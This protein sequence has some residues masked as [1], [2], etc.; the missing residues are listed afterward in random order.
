[1]TNPHLVTKVS[2]TTLMSLMSKKM[3]GPA[4]QTAKMKIIGQ[5][6]CFCEKKWLEI[7]QNI[8]NMEKYGK[9]R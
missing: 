2:V 6:S 9:Y 7:W 3:V 1:M 5:V 8:K 4:D